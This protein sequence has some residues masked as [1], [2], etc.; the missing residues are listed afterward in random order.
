MCIPDST[1]VTDGAAA[2][3]LPSACFFFKR[4]FCAA[5]NSTFFPSTTS[6]E[7]SCA[8]LIIITWQCNY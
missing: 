5:V 8:D 2:S 7:F 6:A 3:F 4:F 1:E